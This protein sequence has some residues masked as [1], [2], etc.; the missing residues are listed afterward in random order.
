MNIRRIKRQYISIFKTNKAKEDASLNFRLKIDETT[1]Y[2]SEEIKH[3]ELM[4]EMHKKC[5]EL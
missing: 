2:L 4:S 5:V 1:N 3:N